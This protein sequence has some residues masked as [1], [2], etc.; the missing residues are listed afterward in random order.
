M[1]HRRALL[2]TAA[3][4][5]LAPLAACATP[6]A[7]A[8]TVTGEDARLRTLLDAE[9]E[10]ILVN[11]PE[12]ATG[13]G[14]DKG[15]KAYLK[16]RLS[17]VSG[18][19]VERDEATNVRRLAAL[20]RIDRGAL[21]PAA[22]VD[23]DTMLEDWD[24]GDTSRQFAYGDAGYPNPYVVS[25]LT[26]V[27]QAIP[28]FLD[29]QHEVKTREDAEAYLSRL[30]G[31]AKQV[32]DETERMRADVGRG[33][34][35][36]DFALDNALKQLRSLR[37]TPAASAVLV[38]SLKRKTAAAAVAGDWERRAT[39]LYDGPISA[40]LDRQIAAVTAARAGAT[41]DAGIWKLSDGA[42]YYAWGLRTQTTTTKSADEIHR[43]GLE[44]CAAITAQ[45]DT[46]LRREGLTQ[47]EVGQRV[48]ALGR[49]PRFLYPNTDAGKAKLLSDLDAQMKAL[50]ARLPEV[51]DPLPKAACDI[52]RVPVEIEA[53]APGGYYQSPTLDGSRPGAYY[54][55]LRDTAE[56]PRFTLPTLTYHEAVPGH[57]LQIAIAQ[58][59]E[60]LPLLR[61]NTGFNAYQEGWGLYA[62]Q[63]A[64]EMGVYADDP[65]GRVGYLQSQLFRAARLVV[66]TGLHDKRWTRERAIRWMT[67]TTGDQESSIATEV[68]RYCVW[69]GQACGY[70][71]G[72]LEIGRLRE[73][74][75]ARLGPAFDLK[76]FHRTVLAAGAIP[77]TVLEQVVG[78][79]GGTAAA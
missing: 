46:I 79:W 13:L 45:I 50:Y 11:V 52:K 77:L 40:A 9:F 75:K 31:F 1:L 43:L 71:I 58:E 48:Q 63:L 34:T 14:L 66:D 23:Y 69:P 12:Q 70:M 64:D 68:E 53:G 36:P 44:Q 38:Q 18:A 49:D 32:N 74:A 51:F 2:A 25:Q 15:A 7:G 28:D 35:P 59:T 16:A 29:S 10:R 42:A 26:G 20:R 6:G 17:D 8:A 62:E 5:G 41:H 73:A 3:A 30:Q 60:S 61:R 24:A 65:Y 57:H 76:G 19:G 72:R 78:A 37:G 39:A 47:G 54:I 67:D 22:Q 55:N 21:S 4:A 33:V 56:W 27:Y